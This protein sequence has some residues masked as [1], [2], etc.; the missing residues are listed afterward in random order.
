MVWDGEV[1]NYT[2]WRDLIKKELQN[3]QSEEEKMFFVASHI[4]CTKMLLFIKDCSSTEEMFM[5]LDTKDATVLEVLSDMEDDLKNL[6][7]LPENYQFENQN[8]QA[9]IMYIRA[10]RKN[11]CLFY[12]P[13][14][15]ALS[16]QDKL[17]RRNAKEL[18]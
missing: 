14:R 8:I 10:C 6:T 5:C 11:D 12:G 18:L 3:F 15:F 9:L 17:S 16:F 7:S 4:S 2:P 1:M 13:R